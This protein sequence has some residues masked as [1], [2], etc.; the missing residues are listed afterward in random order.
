MLVIVKNSLVGFS[1]DFERVSVY[2][3]VCA[4]MS[5]CVSVGIYIVYVYVHL[6]VC[7]CLWVYV[8]KCVYVCA[9]V[10]MH[11]PFALSFSSTVS[12]IACI[13][14]KMHESVNSA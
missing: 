14:K 6:R 11:G 3:C 5:V 13:K 7:V 12:Q 1:E 4:C 9:C 2:V 8:C 10:R